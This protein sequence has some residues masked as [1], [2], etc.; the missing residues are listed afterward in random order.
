[1]CRY[2]SLWNLNVEILS[3]PRTKCSKLWCTTRP[4]KQVALLLQRGRVML[5]PSVVSFNSVKPR[6]ESFIIV[7]STSDLPLPTIKCCCITLRLLVTNTLLLS[8]AIN[9]LCRL[10]ATS[11][12][13]LVL[14]VAAEC[15]ALGFR[16]V[17]MHT[18]EPDIDS[19]LWLL[20]IPPAFNA[21]VRLVP[22]GIL[23]WRL[24]GKTRMWWTDIQKVVY[25]VA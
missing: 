17:H 6:A 18:M 14:S 20:P 13:N 25:T 15:I 16:T 24:G 7:N 8:L 21:Y 10:P 5:C 9:K 22:V 1:M 2:N 3:C 11:V 4:I 12:I 19:K 23:S